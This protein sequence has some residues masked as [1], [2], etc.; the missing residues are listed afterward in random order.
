MR[1]L[2]ALT[3]KIDYMKRR[4]TLVNKTLIAVRDHLEAALEEKDTVKREEMLKT[5]QI[6][7]RDACTVANADR[8]V[9]KQAQAAERI[10]GKAVK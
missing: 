7:L 4:W 8:K 3:N 1:Q 2:Q 9:A 10:F 5:F 6:Q